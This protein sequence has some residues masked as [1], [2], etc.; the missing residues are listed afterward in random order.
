MTLTD[1]EMEYIEQKLG[2]KPNSLEEEMLDVMFSEHCSYK[3]SRPVL[4]LFPTEG[5]NIVMGP[6]DDAGIVS[7]TDKLALAVAIESHN[8]PSAIEPYNGSGTGVGG[9]VRDIISMGAK[10]IAVL[11]SLRLGSLEDDRT[12]YLFEYMVKGASDYGAN[13]GVPTV[14][15]EL[16]FDD[17]Y[18]TNPLVNVMAI[19]LVEKDKIYKGIAPN[20]GDVFL[21]MGG[22]TGRDGIH[23]V[24]FASE[25]LSED[26]EEED[27]SAVAIG[28]SIT[29]KKVIDATFEILETIDV[30]G[31]KDLGGGGLTCCI[32]ELVDKCGNGAIVDWNSVPVREEG[33]TPY[34]VMLSESQERMVFVINPKDIDEAMAI[35]EKHEV[36]STIIGKVTDTKLMEVEDIKV[37]E[38]NQIIAS[39]PANLLADPPLIS[40]EMK[41]PVKQEKYVNV[42][43]SPIDEAILKILSSPNIANKK[44]AYNQFNSEVQGRTIV[45][46]GDDAAVLQIDDDTAIALA[47]DCNSIHTK[48]SPYDGGAGSLAEAI[49][50]VVSMGAEPY[51]V[52]DNLNFGNPEN[53]E[54]FWQFNKCVEGMADLAS[55]FNTPVISGNVSFYNETAGVIINP[56]P[57]VG[58]VGVENIHNVRTMNFKRVGDKIVLVGKTYDEVDGSQYHKILHDLEQ[59]DAPKI[60]IDDEVEAAKSILNIVEK[61]PGEYEGTENDIT[62]IHDCSAGGIAIT[63]S[64]MAIKGSLGGEIDLSTIP[65]DENE[66]ISDS[67]K[68]FSESHGRYIITVR[69]EALDDVLNSID[70]PCACIGEVKGDSLKFTDI[71]VEISVEDLKN[72][73]NG[74]IEKLMD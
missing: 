30:S 40:R 57:V 27:S 62:A 38:K 69:P 13:I 21:L 32:S 3:S 63:L 25:E 24:T 20:V 34:E 73:Y 43:D 44:W 46:P 71:N 52:V 23:G 50:N 19:G 37:E 2:R 67:N 26:A 72:A 1:P 15:G 11:D 61:D 51:T 12:R 64:E 33:M 53:P 54:I 6:G 17:S 41:A 35:C 31:V 36:I 29:K 66:N 42:K 18:R 45:K 4:K 68:L 74:V 58:V 10:P 9:I 7:V 14:G 56:S 22:K 55:K 49:R 48:L 59:G 39:M 28:D 5:E 60:R 16:E 8:H 65:T 47:C 70:A